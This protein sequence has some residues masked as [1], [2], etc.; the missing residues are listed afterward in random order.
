[1]SD[2]YRRYRAIKQGLMQFYHPQPQ[3]HRER[4][5]NTLAALIC[6]LAGGKHAHLSII[7]DH[8]PSNNAKQESI[9]ERFRRWLKHED[10]TLDGWFL[11]VAQELL[12]A[13]AHQPLQLVMDGSAVGRGCVALMLSVVYHGRAAL[14]LGRGQG[15]ERTLSSG[16]ALRAACA[17]AGSLAA[18]CLCDFLGRWRV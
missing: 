5:F 3:G 2:T 1:M 13:L 15:Q 9:I 7:A 8:A 11:P 4:H 18:Q 17:G 6:G 10:Q 14:G 12:T 16:D